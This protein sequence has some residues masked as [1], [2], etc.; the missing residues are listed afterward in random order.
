VITLPRSLR[1]GA[2]WHVA[3]AGF[4]LAAILAGCTGLKPPE[5]QDV[6]IYVLDARL[7]INLRQP[8]RNGVL[9]TGTPRAWPG[10]DTPRIAYVRQPY[11]LDYFATGRWA[12]APVRM[13]G[14]LIA[15]ALEQ[16]GG[17]HAVVHNPSVVASNV[18]LDTELVRL[19]HEF[20]GGP[21]R[22]RITLRAQLIGTS[23]RRVIAAREFE[24]IEPAAAD[25]VYSG[26][27]AANRA[28]ERVL[29]RLAEFC[30]NTVVDR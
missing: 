3:I 18:R 20:L 5:I 12:D 14:P 9:A 4:A 13:L 19:Q 17:F 15:I 1:R 2:R 10:F 27:A 29:I 30:A 23:D 26:V 21:S 22:V 6:S 8:Q 24:E 28:L 16:G 7:A 25:N 11:E